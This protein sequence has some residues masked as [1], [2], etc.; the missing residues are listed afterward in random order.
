MKESLVRFGA[1]TSMVGIV[2]VGEE[3]HPMKVGCLLPNIGL[4]HRIGPHRLNVKVARKLAECGFPTLRFD[5]SGV[6][7]SPNVRTSD[8]VIAQAV[9][10]MRHA[11]DHLQEHY[12]I[13][14]FLVFGICSGAQNGYFLASKDDRVVG[15][16]MYDG[17]DF[18][19]F[20]SKLDHFIFQFRAAPWSSI[21]RR[22]LLRV[23]SKSQRKPDDIF[24]AALDEMHPTST[25]FRNV[26]QQLV[27]RGVKIFI[28]YSGSRRASDNN[29]GL[30]GGLGSPSLLDKITY[31][32][33]AEL[34]H[35]ATSLAS[36]QRLLSMIGDWARQVVST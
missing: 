11:M 19:S 10:D 27:S 3:A 22:V 16:M 5:L 14:R 2:T 35:T 17:F 28:F 24:A 9:V 34:D 7:D 20:R 31:R 23:R 18:P 12:G 32:F 8:D 36:Q 4:A 25:Q 1:E 30:L 13:Q 29:R 15:L 33:D 6:G 21:G 26:L